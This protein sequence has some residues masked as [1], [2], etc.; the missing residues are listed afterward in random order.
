MDY[1]THYSFANAFLNYSLLI[2]Y[3]LLLS[4]KGASILLLTPLTPRFTRLLITSLPRDPYLLYALC[5]IK[6]HIKKEKTKR[7]S[8]CRELESFETYCACS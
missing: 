4:N 8:E 1:K 2:L 7:Q 6:P 5:N 3:T